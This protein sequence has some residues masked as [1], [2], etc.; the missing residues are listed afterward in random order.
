MRG[1]MDKNKYVDKIKDLITS[2]AKEYSLKSTPDPAYFNNLFPEIKDKIKA[3]FDIYKFSQVDEVTLQSYFETAKREYL[4]TDPI[5]IDL[6]SFLTKKGFKTWLTSERRNKVEWNYTDRYFR[7]LEKNGRAE[8]VLDETKQSSLEIME[9]LGDPKSNNPAYV[10]GLVVGEVQSGKTGNFNAVIN[11]AIDCGYGLII[12]LSGI[13]EDLRSQTQQRIES[14]VIGEGID[15]ESTTTSSKGVGKIEMFGRLGSSEVEQVV[16]ITSYKTDFNKSLADAD[17]SL[18]HTNILV[19]KKNVNVLRNLIVWLHDYLDQNKEKHNIPLLILDDEADNASLNNSGAKGREY[20]SKTNGHIRTLL[21][22]FNRKTY[23]GYTATPFANVLQDRNGKPEKDWPVKYRLRGETKEKRLR[24]VANIFPDDFIVLLNPPSN[25]IGAKQI[26]ETIEPIDNRA[27]EKIPLVHVVSDHIENF[28][29]RVRRDNNL[30]VESFNNNDEWNKE[31][32]EFGSYLDFTTYREYSEGTRSSKTTDMFPEA[33]PQ[34]L[35][36]AVMC[37]IL[38]IAV[39]ESRKHVMIQSVLYNPHNTMLIHVSRFTMWQNTTKKLVEDYVI[40]ISSLISNDKPT[41]AD[42]IYFKFEKIWYRYYAEIVDSIAEYLPSSG[43]GDSFMAP[44]IFES[45]K[46]HLPEAVHGL[47]V[48]AINSVTKDKLEYPNRNPKKIIAIGGNRLS[49]GFT[50]EGLTINYFIRTTNYSDTLLQ[51]GRWFGYRPG[52][53]DCCKLFIT[54]DSIDKYNSTTRC[55]EELEAEFRKM[56]SK[57][58]TPENFV[59]R[60]RKHPGTLKITRPSILKNTIDVKWSFQDQL[61]MTTSFDVRKE[62]MERVWK[63]FTQDLAPLFKSKEKG[64][65]LITY[66]TD[67]R[68]II[69]LLKK[70]NNFDKAH[71]D[72]MTKFIQLCIDKK[73]LVKWTV[74][75]KTRGNAKAACGKGTLTPEESNLPEQITLSIRRGPRGKKKENQRQEFLKDKRIFKA[76]G[77][78]ANIISSNN[79]FG[80]LLTSDEIEDAISEFR[81]DRKE[82]YLKKDK[83]LT[84]RKATEKADKVNVPE[85][86]YREK[87]KEDEGLL[88]IYL[89]D[90]YYSF[91]QERDMEEDEKFKKLVEREEYNLD[92]P[93]VGYAIGFPPIENDP[94]GVYV[95]GDY[96]LEKDEGENEDINEDDSELPSDAE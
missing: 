63:S 17:F 53:L 79:D 28:P 72:M 48:K 64:Y 40:N 34:S 55:I 3:V 11:R 35:Q 21:D 78:S 15:I 61:E 30:G 20:A 14:D 33:I 29:T 49:R 54:Q 92:I 8:S 5:D 58:K 62:K 38:A 56:E 59:L 47:E 77:A 86:V 69:D 82:Y 94:G 37:F 57:G 10:K 42:S 52:Y 25:Y 6:S 41:S 2:E 32:G 68:G 39:R 90:S 1:N 24:Q 51:M 23:L 91:N 26:F 87:M 96:E 71:V 88:I 75:V 31:A 80:L 65:N 12:V 73:K 70:E 95:Q 84:E 67:G 83:T 43:Y 4:S 76:T 36:D 74:A 27:K 60:V 85:R 18:N 89:F 50:L 19:C 66:K 44:I 7:L 93:I 45:L 81:T 16:S 22:L 13:M 9:K 46:S